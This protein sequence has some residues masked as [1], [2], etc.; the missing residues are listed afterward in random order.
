MPLFKA[1]SCKNFTSSNGE[2]YN[3]LSITEAGLIS[4]TPSGVISGVYNFT[5]VCVDQCGHSKESAI[6]VNISNYADF[7]SSAGV[8]L[9]AVVLAILF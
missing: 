2:K 9:A 6:E 5:G 3:W 1:V 7:L 8:A 4:L